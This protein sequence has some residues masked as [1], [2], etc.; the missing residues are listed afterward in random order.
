MKKFISL[1]LVLVLSLSL[2]ACGKSDAVKALEARIDGLT[3]VTLADQATVSEIRST[4]MALP[5][6]AREDVENLAV[7]EAA[8]A[9]IQEA[10]Q[11]QRD[12]IDAIVAEYDPQEALT[13]LREM[14]DVSYAR[15]NIKTLAQNMLKSY[16]LNRGYDSDYSGDPEAGGDYKA[17]RVDY[18][19]ES[20]KFILV[21]EDGGL[22][23]EAQDDDPVNRMTDSDYKIYRRTRTQHITSST[24]YYEAEHFR[25]GREFLFTS[26]T[27]SIPAGCTKAQLNKLPLDVRCNL[28]L[29][30]P[31]IYS[32]SEIEENMHA[33]VDRLLDD[34]N[35]CLRQLDMPFTAY[36][37]M[38]IFE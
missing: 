1:V 20:L 4:Y 29:Y 5:E 12:E 26:W 7:L 13:L 17:V 3:N 30:W 21:L 18:G 35:D 2:C 9:V 34:M 25:T 37:L 32:E 24:L 6:E 8:E 16:V 11:K 38:G 27:T 28:P 33:D 19:G 36:E 23:F 31:Y 22:M 14:G 15:Y 10:L